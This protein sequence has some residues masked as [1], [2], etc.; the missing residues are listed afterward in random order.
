MVTGNQT[1]R[2]HD[3]LPTTCHVCGTD[4][5]LPSQVLV[6][7][8]GILER[9]PT[10]VIEK[11]ESRERIAR[12]IIQIVHATEV[13]DT[14]LL[15][16]PRVHKGLPGETQVIEQPSQC[17]KGIIGAHPDR[18]RFLDAKVAVQCGVAFQIES[19]SLTVQ[20]LQ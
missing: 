20:G 9:I 18:A 14:A 8:L 7:A 6:D 10:A 3:G 5:L 17:D 13:V 12:G 11:M 4:Q 15:H 1:G 19:H 16:D 2:L